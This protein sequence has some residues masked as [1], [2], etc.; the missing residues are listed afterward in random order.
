MKIDSTTILIGIIAV[1]LFGGIGF[2]LIGTTDDPENEEAENTTDLDIDT[3]ADIGSNVATDTDV[4]PTNNVGTVEAYSPD[5][6]DSNK[7]NVLFFSAAWC[8]TCAALNRD[9]EANADEIPADLQI[10][11]IDYD[12][13]RDLRAQY[14]IQVQHTLVEVD[15]NGKEL[16]RWSGGNTLNSILDR[17][18]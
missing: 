13:Q 15:A 7:T 14:S 12:E 10:L 6:L 2:V 5:K 1:V 3:D 4:V 17:L 9:L 8:T 11:R 18:Q 16:Q